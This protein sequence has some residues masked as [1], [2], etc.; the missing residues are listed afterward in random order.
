MSQLQWITD[1][2]IVIVTTVTSSR[3]MLRK[4]HKIRF[5]VISMRGFQ[6][7]AELLKKRICEN[8]SNKR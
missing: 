2:V 4:C 6:I 3:E 1:D 8:R 7:S 5:L